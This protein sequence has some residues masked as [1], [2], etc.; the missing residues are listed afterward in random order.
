MITHGWAWYEALVR[1]SQGEPFR[2]VIWSWPSSQVR[3][4]IR[5]IRVKAG[6][7]NVESFYLGTF[8]S[9][10]TEDSSV[11]LIGYSYGG[12]IIPGALHLL[13]GGVIDGYGIDQP[14]K[15]RRFGAALVAA[16]THWH[17]M[18]PGMFHERA[19]SQLNS[20]LVLYNPCDPVLK[21]YGIVEKRHK[22]V[23]LGYTGIAG[24]EGLAESEAQFEQMNVSGYIGKTHNEYLY[25]G[26]DA[27][28]QRI[29]QISFR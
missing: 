4:Q 17:W 27:I 29:G 9:R 12:R 28:I 18:L 6:R 19:A 10:I 26:T 14:P 22:P 24:L 5:D 25:I 16:A 7:A 23:A 15:T 11:S 1:Q 8:L 13:G 2:L 20:L 21:R 3:G